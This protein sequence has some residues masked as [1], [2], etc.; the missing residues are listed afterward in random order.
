MKRE[1]NHKPGKT[2]IWLRSGLATSALLTGSPLLAHPDAAHTQA[3]GA[4]HGLAHALMNLP[5]AAAATVAVVIALWMLIRL[6]KIRTIR[7]MT[8]DSPE[9]TQE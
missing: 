2:S 1:N 5:V 3:T 9:L 4:S 8:D 6:R 7:Q